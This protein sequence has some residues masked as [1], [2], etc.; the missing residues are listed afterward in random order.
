MKGGGGGGGGGAG[1]LAKEGK[2]CVFNKYFLLIKQYRT[3]QKFYLLKLC[4][5][6][7]VRMRN[8]FARCVK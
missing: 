7:T 3:E 5:F 8:F 4:S 6:T 2:K 1:G